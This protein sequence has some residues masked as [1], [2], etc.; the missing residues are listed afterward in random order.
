MGS[1]S[2]MVRHINFYTVFIKDCDIAADGRSSLGEVAMSP[3]LNPGSQRIVLHWGAKP[4]D[5]DSYLTVPQSDPAKPDCVINYKRK[6]G[7][8]SV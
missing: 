6:V 2:C 1:Y 5:L 3:L 7:A 8:S 4:K